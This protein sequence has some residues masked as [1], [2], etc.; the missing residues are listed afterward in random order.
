MKIFVLLCICVVCST[1]VL[2]ADIMEFKKGV[3]FNHKLHQSQ[4]VGKCFACHENI[5]V[6]KD[7]KTITTTEPGKI[8][9]FGKEWAHK[10]CK[11]C[12][13]TFDEGPV[14]CKGCHSKK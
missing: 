7:E 4:K 6:S 9:E 3:V 14:D 2:A 5:S 13:E 12:H 10:Y 1:S 8:K 11:D